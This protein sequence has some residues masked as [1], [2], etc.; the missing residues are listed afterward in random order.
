MGWMA[1][2]KFVVPMAWVVSSFQFFRE[3]PPILLLP[4]AWPSALATLPSPEPPA[5]LSVL[6]LA[7]AIWLTGSSLLLATWLIQARRSRRTRLVR[8][9]PT[10]AGILQQVAQAAARLGLAR[11]PQCVTV[12]GP[13]GPAIAGVFSPVLIWPQGLEQ[14]LTPAEIEAILLHEL[15]HVG[16]RDPLW[17]TLQSAIV[18]L[19]WFNPVAWLLHRRIALEAEKACDEI[20]VDLTRDADTYAGS[21]VKAV[22]F[23]LGS[24]QPDLAATTPPIIMRLKNILAHP[25]RPRRPLAQSTALAV[26]AL[27]ILLSGFSG[28]LTAAGLPERAAT[29]GP[30]QPAPQKRSGT[31]SNATLSVDFP[32]TNVRDILKNVANLFEFNILIPETVQG[33]VN[34]KL[35]DVTWRQIYQEALTPLGYTFV[36]EENLV[37]IV[38]KGD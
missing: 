16:R 34:L 31:D 6:R 36:V 32:D 21:I 19:L 37:R 4:A 18:R 23:S 35:R 1:L 10:P 13:H 38:R 20:V 7:V 12:T 15:A 25:Q 27:A 28:S 17:H 30:T 9:V 14:S 11:L 8:I 29:P 3:V 2:V 22:K 33:R 26:A 24:L 5:S